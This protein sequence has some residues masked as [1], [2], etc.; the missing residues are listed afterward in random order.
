[1]DAFIAA[2]VAEARAIVTNPHSPQ[3][4][5]DLAWRVIRQHGARHAC[6]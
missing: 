3:P 4:L 2:R 1:M 6:A 5:V